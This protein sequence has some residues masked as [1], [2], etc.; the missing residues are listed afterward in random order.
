MK[1]LWSRLKAARVQGVKFTTHQQAINEVMDWLHFYNQ[2]R[3][4]SMLNYVSPMQFEAAWHASQG[5]LAA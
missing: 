5:K 3:L 1:N 4:R 2:T